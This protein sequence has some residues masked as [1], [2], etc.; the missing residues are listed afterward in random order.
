MKPRYFGAIICTLLISLMAPCVSSNSSG[1]NFI[2][3]THADSS[4]AD[5]KSVTISSER[6]IIASSYSKTLEFHDLDT[7]EFLNSSTFTI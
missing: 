5:T 2:G 6:N 3:V 1:I 7:L 4:S